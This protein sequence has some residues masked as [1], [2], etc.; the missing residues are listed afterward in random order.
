ML[1]P[2]K[3]VDGDQAVFEVNTK[4]YTEQTGVPVRVDY[5]AWENM[6][7]QTAV[8]A[9]TGAGPDIVL[10]FGADPHLYATKIIELT[11]VAQIRRG[12]LLARC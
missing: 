8:V 10:G 9:N 7:P 1:R 6:T 3:F 2:S 5:L 11:D 12:C 4:R